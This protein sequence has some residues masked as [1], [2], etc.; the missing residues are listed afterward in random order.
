MTSG[1]YS[2]PERCNNCYMPTYDCQCDKRVF[3]TAHDSSLIRNEFLENLKVIENK[4]H[5]TKLTADQQI[6]ARALE[7]A[8]VGENSSFSDQFFINRAAKFED[9]IREGRKG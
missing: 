9:Y 1:N 2:N 6:R 3:G 8:M 7:C 5:K 4:P